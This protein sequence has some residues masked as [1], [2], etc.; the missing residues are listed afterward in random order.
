MKF[1]RSIGLCFFVIAALVQVPTGASADPVSTITLPSGTWNATVT[2]TGKDAGNTLAFG[3]QSPQSF[4]ICGN[5]PTAG[6]CAPGDTSTSSGL[7][8][9]LVFYMT[10]QTCGQTFQSTDIN[11]AH[12]DQS[13]STHWTIGWDDSGSPSETGCFQDPDFNDLTTSVVASPTTFDSASGFCTGATT[14]T[15]ST[16]TVA[17]KDDPTVSMI[18]IPA[19]ATAEPQTIT[20]TEGPS[21]GTFCGGTTC[22]GQVLTFTSNPPITFDGVNDFTHPAVVT[23]IFDKSVKQGSQVYVD[24]LD[25]FG[26][27][28]VKNCTTPGTAIPHPCV[29]AKN[30]TLPNGDREFIILF[31]EG[32]PIIGKR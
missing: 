10:D 22:Q 14:C 12:I 26:P 25:G 27:K 16:G 15:I 9:E 21:T 5:P 11:H 4:Q 32:D 6:G 8:G 28:L 31:T 3:M 1:A 20:M 30:I 19:D 17:T 13:D 7:S 29:S 18:T 24:K 23:M 2:V